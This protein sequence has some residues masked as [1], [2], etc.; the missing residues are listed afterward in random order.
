MM[1]V[2]ADNPLGA[3]VNDIV[4][5]AIPTELVVKGSF[6][7]FLVPV[8]A[9]FVGYLGGAKIGG[10]FGLGEELPGILLG[11]LFLI[12]SFFLV[13]WYDQNIVSRSQMRARIVGIKAS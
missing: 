4:E 11:L 5:F 3:K 12:V 9:L 7:L 13:R 2:E 8:I 1:I 10:S 6:I